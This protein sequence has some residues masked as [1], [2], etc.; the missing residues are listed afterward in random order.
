MILLRC[1]H[2]VH[3]LMEIHQLLVLGHVHAHRLDS[4]V[5][6][7]EIQALR[8]DLM[9]RQLLGPKR[10]LSWVLL[11]HHHLLEVSVRVEVAMIVRHCVAAP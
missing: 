2:L 10:R 8:S 6:V 4:F 7:E 5:M 3:T 9:Q 1:L 11:H